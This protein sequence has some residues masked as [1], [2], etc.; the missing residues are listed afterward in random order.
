MAM[1]H[2]DH[3]VL[4]LLG[5][6]IVTLGAGTLS[7]RITAPYAK[8]RLTRGLGLVAGASLIA[9]VWYLS[10][11]S[12][13]Q[14]APSGLRFVG[15]GAIRPQ[16]RSPIAPRSTGTPSFSGTRSMRSARRERPDEA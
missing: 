16:R 4:F 1:P 12:H 15:R 6:F 7:D 8:R 13:G 9:G 3:L 10:G 5:W 14:L 11:T 2:M